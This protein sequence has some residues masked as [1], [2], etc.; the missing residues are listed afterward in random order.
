MK[1]NGNGMCEP[2]HPACRN[3]CV[4]P[5]NITSQYG[6]KPCEKEV[7]DGIKFVKC[8]GGNETCPRGTY[9][10]NDGTVYRNFSRNPGC[11]KCHPLCSQCRAYGFHMSVCEC[12][13]Y[14]KSEQ[15]LETCP[16]DFYGDNNK[17]SCLPCS[18]ECRGCSGPTS[19]YCFTCRNY[20]FYSE[21]NPENPKNG[22][23]TCVPS[24]G[25]DFSKVM[26]DPLGPICTPTETTPSPVSQTFAQINLT[27]R[28]K[29]WISGNF[30]VIM[31]PA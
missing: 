25:G 2:C 23:F 30:S 6:C 4:G 31:E 27:Q 15:C 20:R 3:G 24:C 9:L 21:A 17:K 1:Y 10:T 28:L 13:F 7:F 11:M 16:E 5:G 19:A 12:K 14:R 8:I 22:N 26:E 18:N 29:F